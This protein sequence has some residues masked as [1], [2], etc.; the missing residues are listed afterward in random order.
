MRRLLPPFLS[1]PTECGPQDQVPVEEGSAAVY[2][3]KR[4]GD[5]RLGDYH[6]GVDAALRAGH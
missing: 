5:R 6:Q 3:I 2:R 1:S 4:R